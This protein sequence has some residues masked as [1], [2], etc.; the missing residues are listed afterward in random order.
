MFI[1]D[2]RDF[3][4]PNRVIQKTGAKIPVKEKVKMV[5]FK[6]F[7]FFYQIAVPVL[8]FEVA[9]NLA[10]GA[11]FLQILIASTF[12]LFV[13]LPLHPLPDNEFPKLDEAGNLPYSWLRHQFEVTNDLT[14]NNTFIRFVL[15]NF[16]YHVAHHLFPNIS[17][18][19]AHEVTDEIKK[20]A[21]ENNFRYKQFPLFTALRKHY[22]LLKTNATSIGDVME[23]TM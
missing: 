13:L 2:F 17:Y 5:A 12:A 18:E 21:A 22:D 15:G 7:Y 8:F 14:E 1:R 6:V 23:E 9:W 3:F 16:N 10:L 4:D 19:Y 20:F 11:W